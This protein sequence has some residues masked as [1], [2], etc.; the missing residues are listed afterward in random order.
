MLF[1]ALNLKK[2]YI[3]DSI[4]K[5]T[6]SCQN[7]VLRHGAVLGLLI[8]AGPFDPLARG[9]S[10]RGDIPVKSRRFSFPIQEENVREPVEGWRSTKKP[11]RPPAGTLDYTLVSNG[12]Q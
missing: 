6:N 1:L 2:G 10:K 7:V 11:R 4:I 8:L 5:L 12:K 3:T 9:L